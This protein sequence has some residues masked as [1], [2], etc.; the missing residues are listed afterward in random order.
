MSKNKSEYNE[1]MR[2]YMLLRYHAR[3]QEAIQMLG[4]V[5][6]ACGTDQDLEF[7]HVEP[8]EKKFSV[9]TLWSISKEKFHAEVRK[10]QLLCEEHHKAKHAAKCGTVSGFRNC[11]CDLC[12]E[13][14][15]AYMRT[16]KRN[17]RVRS[18]GFG[19]AGTARSGQFG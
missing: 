18:T 14:R 15:N 7:D 10:C 8:A 11:K 17:R 4:G 13:A 1:Y 19:T 5:C 9:G 12:R 2:G 6:V 16:W 3:R